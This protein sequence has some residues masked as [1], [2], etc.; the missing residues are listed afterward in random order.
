MA[1]H[2]E[3]HADNP[4]PRIIE[5]VVQA[6]RDGAVILYP[7]DTVHAI[8]CELT[9]KEGQKRI[10]A[11]R[12]LDDDKP[13]TFV[14][15]SLSHISDYA[16]VSDMAYKLL[17]RLVPGPYTFLLPASRLV[18]KLVMNARRKTAGI[19]VPAHR[20][21]QTIISDLATPLISMSAKLPHADP[22]ESLDDLHAMFDHH[23]DIIIEEM[24]YGDHH[25]G[26]GQVSTMID[27]TGPQPDIIRE[28][29]GLEEAEKWM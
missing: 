15:S 21:C 6:M 29:L 4:E 18:P 26:M 16:S 17:R 19:R 24:Q 3:I 12:Q 7:T 5:A 22:P 28:G 20:I 13:L 10:R 27:L 1:E 14:C 9:N 23:V 2:Y 8:G 11:L 25:P